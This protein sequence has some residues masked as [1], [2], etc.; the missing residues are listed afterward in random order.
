MTISSGTTQ[1]LTAAQFLRYYDTRVVAELLSDNGVKVPD[2]AG[3]PIL[4]EL[5]QAAC[6]EVE[7][8]ALRGGRYTS[9]DLAAL[10]ASASN[11]AVFLRKLVAS[12][13]IDSL[14]SRRA[15]VNEEELKDRKWVLESLKRLRQGEEIFGFVEVQKAGTTQATHDNAANR[16]ARQGI[17][18]FA[19]PFFGSRG[20]DRR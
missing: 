17:S 18:T 6:G 7:A 12:V 19:S 1:Y 9:D 15:R 14:R 11:H 20:G 13:C 5:L 10:A 4:A 16:Q 8:S 2:P 3:S